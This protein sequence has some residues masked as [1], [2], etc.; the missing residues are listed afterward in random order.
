MSSILSP[1]R[2]PP[3][4]HPPKIGPTVPRLGD[5]LIQQGVLTPENLAIALREQHNKPGRLLG[6][7]LLDAKMVSPVQ[8]Q[9]ALNEHMSRIELPPLPESV[10]P[11]AHLDALTL[12]ILAGRIG[13]PAVQ[14]WLD[15][16]RRKL[17]FHLQVEEC[18]VT[19][20]EEL[21]GNQNN[22]A[23]DLSAIRRVRHIIAEA[24]NLHASDIHMT[25]READG[26]GGLKVQFRVNGSIEPAHGEYTET[27]GA[28]MMRAM[29][30][31]MAAVA[32]KQVVDTEDQHAII[33]DPAFLKSLTGQALGIA[34][35]R[36]ARAPLYNGLN[37]AARLLYT[38]NSNAFGNERLGR[39]GYSKR[40][41][42]VMQMLARRTEGVNLITGPTGAGKSTTLAQEVQTILE[43]REG[44][45]IITIEDPVEYEFK[46]PNVWQYRISNANTDDEKSEAF[47]GKLKTALRQDPDIIVVGE[48]RGLETARE[49]INAALTGHQVWTTLHVSDPFMIPQ[50]LIGMG[51]DGFF[52]T[53]PKLLSSL[54]AQRL[55][56]TLCPHCSVPWN[57]SAIEHLPEIDL[58]NLQAW[59]PMAPFAS[60]VR[61]RG[62]GCP[63][64]RSG[65]DGR[66][67][68][69]QV[70]P[71]DVD[72]LLSMIEH[73][74]MRARTD[75]MKRADKEADMMTHGVLKILQGQIDPRSL[76]EVLGPIEAPAQDLRQ[77]T[78]DDL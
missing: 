9:V 20:L 69:A 40:Q 60:G 21:R 3:L 63:R 41:L 37:L 47:A 42:N 7:I 55:A 75:Y 10:I 13:Q 73:G 53:D 71:T 38:Q 44:V 51:I 43:V 26:R 5:L 12:Y 77:L 11:F 39:L 64:C 48:I 66:T 58:H 45:R 36:L 72:L 31:G 65:Y 22:D 16:A 24:V 49:A 18:T 56:K 61:L 68:I 74:P 6:Q 27:E 70:I 67:V 78:A 35:I 76:V 14:S 62:P 57:G 50:R 59:M 8:L 17:G 2:R 29:F 30:Q 25:L 54:I 23:A 32:D 15:D 19:K 4:V 34:G 46:H 33:V 52:L 28:Q 1:F